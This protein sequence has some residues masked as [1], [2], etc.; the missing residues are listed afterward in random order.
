M[1]LQTKYSLVILSLIIPLLAVMAG[2]ILVQNRSV[3]KEMT[4]TSTRTMEK[5]SYNHLKK[6][7]ELLATVLAED[8]AN[9]VYQLDMETIY[10]L[11]QA[12][13]AQEDVI[14]VY[15]F[16]RYRR[17]IH[18]GTKELLLFDKTLDDEFSKKAVA[19]KHPIVQTTEGALDVSV[20]IAIRGELLGGVRINFSLKGIKAKVG[21]LKDDLSAINQDLLRKQVVAVFL[22]AVA[23][24][25]LGVVLAVLASRHLSWPLRLLSA[26]TIPIG[27]GEYDVSIPI[28]RSDEIGELAMSLK[29]M[30]EDLKGLMQRVTALR[31][32]GMAI[33]STLELRAVLGLLLEKID[34]FL[35]Y[36]AATVR[37][38]NKES[39]LL[40]PVA[41]R[42][43]DEE[44]WKAERWR[45]G[46]GPPNIVFESK[47]L[48][49]VRNIQTDARIQDPEF[50]RKHRL[51]SYLGVPLSAKGE[52]L[53]V[54]SFYTKEEH[55]FTDEEREFLSTLAGEAAIA[56]Q[57]SQM[58]EEMAK[59]ASDLLKS[60]RVKD[61]FLGV[62]SH[63][64]RTPLNVVMG[65]AG[66]MRE[67][68]LG[69]INAEQEKGLEK[70]IG[71]GQDQLTMIRN[72]LEATQIEAET[73]KVKCD[74]V[75]LVGFLDDV[76]SRYD[77]PL[78]KELTLNWDYPSDLPVVKTDSERLRHII[79]N[80]INNAIKFTEKGHV[81]IS[82]RIKEGSRE[83]AG[84][85]GQL[86]FVEFKVADTGIGMPKEVL[87]TIFEKFRQ[88]DSSDTRPYGGVGLGLYI[89]KKWTDL[90]GG[91]VEVESKPGRGST[92]TVTIPRIQN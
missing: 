34:L 67:R 84:G 21:K 91:K 80:L 14:Y 2:V 75:S 43:L 16:D 9:P 65:Y 89:V 77:I 68:M 25:A 50:F 72:I 20:P 23:F 44:E 85:N 52:V 56:I 8:L 70:I 19:T 12:V 48:W 88:V 3:I 87:P 69:E 1:R 78:D 29:R 62:M 7:A 81:V 33:T 15:I 64:L 31:E 76:R 18:D 13:K 27:R 17:I 11:T 24:S 10:N 41:C 53:G 54:I 4:S 22:V 42:N 35:P 49:M 58:Y 74:G 30:A 63:E 61:E 79:E 45:A 82:I 39:G 40:E 73:V 55:Y 51:V 90:L 86:E 26:V 37:L 59:L 60:N 38:F 6:R 32:I 57:N 36:S 92:F 83:Q 46:R 5:E 66:M 71:R 47:A 28:K